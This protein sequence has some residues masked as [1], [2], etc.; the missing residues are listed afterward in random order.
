MKK[1]DLPVSCSQ[2]S[3]SF[4][5]FFSVSHLE[6]RENTSGSDMYS[7]YVAVSMGGGASSTN[8]WLCGRWT[9][10]LEDFEPIN[11]LSDSSLEHLSPQK[12]SDQQVNLFFFSPFS[13]TVKGIFPSFVSFL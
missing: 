6:G 7:V 9:A 1:V 3:F 13:H 5:F 11:D 10:A 4:F 12:V 2:C 8:P